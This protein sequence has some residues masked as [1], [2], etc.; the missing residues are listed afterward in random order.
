MVIEAVMTISTIVSR[1][2]FM[3]CFHSVVMENFSK[4][5][6]DVILQ[7]QYGIVDWRRVDMDNTRITFTE[8]K[9]MTW[10]LLKWT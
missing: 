10:W 9:K 4:G 6:I 2:K 8:E 3:T 1:D 5:A 7:E